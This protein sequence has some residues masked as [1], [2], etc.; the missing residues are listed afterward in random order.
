M[1]SD[2]LMY[3]LVF[4]GQLVS[5]SLIMAIFSSVFV[6]SRKKGYV[7]ITIYL[8]LSINSLVLGF[9]TSPVLG[10]GLS[11]IYIS[12]GVVTYFVIKKKLANIVET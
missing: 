6:R 1:G 5:V 4:L 2:F 8:V 7:F 10:S 12:L 9:K 11:V 3:T